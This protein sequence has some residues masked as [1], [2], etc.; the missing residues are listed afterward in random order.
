M[1]GGLIMAS[2]VHQ[3]AHILVLSIRLSYIFWITAGWR[4]FTADFSASRKS[5]QI[6]LT[7]SAYGD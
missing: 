7:F 5:A 4:Q 6:K 3:N 1:L 2:C